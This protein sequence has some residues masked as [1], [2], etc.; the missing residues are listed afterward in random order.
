MT[1]KDCTHFNHCIDPIRT[2]DQEICDDFVR[3]FTKADLIKM[4]I[5]DKH[6]GM[7]DDIR[8][9]VPLPHID[10]CSEK[11]S[12]YYFEIIGMDSIGIVAH[13]PE[14][15]MCCP[16]CGMDK[17]GIKINWENYSV[18]I[19][20]NDIHNKGKWIFGDTD[21]YYDL[22][23]YKCSKCGGHSLENG[24]FCPHCGSPM[25]VEEDDKESEE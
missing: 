25:E 24:R 8:I 9:S 10:E 2:S 20:K 15:Q 22:A 7:D 3:K 5:D 17:F 6:I 19:A 14:I 4:L 21:V 18:T 23:D 13:I 16:N 12:G 11:C 1:C